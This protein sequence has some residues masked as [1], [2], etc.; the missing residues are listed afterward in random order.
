MARIYALFADILDYPAANVFGKA[1]ELHDLL[2]AE[3]AEAAPP[4]NEFKRRIHGMSLGQLQ[5]AYTRT[6][7]L[8]PDCTPNLGCHL[9]GDDVRRNI[10]MVQLKERMERC[11]IETGVELP[12]HFSLVLRLFDALDSAEEQQVLAEDCLIPGLGHILSVLN[13]GEDIAVYAPALQALLILLGVKMRTEKV[14]PA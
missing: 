3:A 7:D 14:V 12:D 9:F 4:F 11:H 6:F 10:F 5:E 2:E 8:Q 13:Q 1:Q